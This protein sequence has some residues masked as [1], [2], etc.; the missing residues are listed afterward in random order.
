MLMARYSE[1]QKIKMG[2]RIKAI[3]QSL[4]LDQCEFGNMVIPKAS[5]S[6]VSRWERGLNTPD[7]SRLE[8]IAKIGDT[9]I[10]FLEHGLNSETFESLNDAYDSLKLQAS[11]TLSKMT[12]DD[13]KK[14]DLGNLS[15]LETLMLGN[16]IS[17]LNELRNIKNLEDREKAE[18]AFNK[19]LVELDSIS[20]T[21]VDPIFDF[22]KQFMET[23]NALNSV[24]YQL[25]DYQQAV[26]SGETQ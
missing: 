19:A 14:L 18:H 5:A 6:N 15:N 17:T 2:K 7:K 4:N 26:Q 9:S 3:R 25:L 10:E 12:F 21:I 23:S 20:G 24:I 11:N 22:N 8:S 1:S 16:F 13:L